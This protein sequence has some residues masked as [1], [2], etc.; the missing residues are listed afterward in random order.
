MYSAPVLYAT[1]LGGVVFNSD[2][3]RTL[4]TGGGIAWLGF[5]A[6]HSL[7]NMI[8]RH[9]ENAPLT[10]RDEAKIEKL[11]AEFRKSSGAEMTDNDALGLAIR[12]GKTLDARFDEAM[13]ALKHGTVSENTKH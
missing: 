11:A 3:T 1:Y 10:A 6:A 4:A 13:A 2:I 9:I 7:V 12:G 8:G 5:F